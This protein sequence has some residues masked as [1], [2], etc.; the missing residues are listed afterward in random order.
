MTAP[1]PVSEGTVLA[2]KYRVER[3][4][5]S[6]GMGVVV[7]ARHLALDERVAIKFLLPE[8]AANHEVITRFL[9][10]GRAAARVRSEHVARV[11]DVGTLADGAPYLVMEYLE[12]NDLGA[13]LR[14]RGPFELEVAV[15]YVLQACEALA[16]AHALGIVH[17]D[18]KPSNLF[19]IRKSDGTPSIKLIDFGISKLVGQREGDV[20]VT[21]SAIMMGSPLFMAPE[22]MKSARDV[23]ARADVWSMGGILY[24][25]LTGRAPFEGETVMGI[26][27]K[28]LL[29]VP[30]ASATV[31][32]LPPEIEDAIAGCLQRDVAARFQNVAQVAAAIARFGPAG[33]GERAARVERILSAGAAPTP[34]TPSTAPPNDA[35]VLAPAAGVATPR[36][37]TPVAARSGAA[38]STAER[39]QTSEGPWNATQR[40]SKKGSRGL[41]VG[42]VAAAALVAAALAFGF[43]ELARRDAAPSP[44]ASESIAAPSPSSSPVVAP[45]AA[46]S[47]VASEAASS[48]PGASAAPSVEASAS[49]APARSAARPRSGGRGGD[50]PKRDLFGDPR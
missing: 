37:A 22:Q 34:L 7:A 50:K 49:A 17:R 8:A 24:M 16:D 40:G 5:G 33:G 19:L 12:G 14:A 30:R 6:G 39:G 27:E 48:E 10:E 41:V 46:A 1:P 2:G 15:E 38:A 31:P 13:L 4:I 25:L 21:A 47:E 35:A 23:D 11:Y 44:A 36:P 20:A 29:G 45:S 42:A 26:Y 32:G 28:I 9:R 43:R 18:L 3:V